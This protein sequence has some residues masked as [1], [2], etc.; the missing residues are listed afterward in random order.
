MAHIPMFPHGDLRL[1]EN[2]QRVELPLIFGRD[3]MW[4][5]DLCVSRVLFFPSPVQRLLNPT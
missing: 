3:Q 5:R 1:P 4:A 2:R